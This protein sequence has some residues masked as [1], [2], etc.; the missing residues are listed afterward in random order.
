METVQLVRGVLHQCEGYLNARC[1]D[2][3]GRSHQVLERTRCIRGLVP[4]SRV[5]CDPLLMSRVRYSRL[6]R[7]CFLVLGGQHYFL[8]VCLQARR[9]E[10]PLLDL[11][12]HGQLMIKAG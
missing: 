10:R 6:W 8:D 2:K 4:F 9:L 11:Q 1:Y 12:E 5:W 7:Y 3:V